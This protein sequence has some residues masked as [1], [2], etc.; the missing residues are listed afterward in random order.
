SGDYPEWLYTYTGNVTDVNGCIS[1]P[2]NV[3]MKFNTVPVPTITGPDPVCAGSTE[4]YITEPGMSGYTWFVTGGTGTSV[5]NSISVVWGAGGT[6]SV[7]VNYTDPDGCTAASATIKTITIYYELTATIEADQTI[8]YN[9]VPELLTSTVSGGQGDYTYQWQILEGGGEVDDVFV[10]IEGATNPTYQPG[11]L[12]VTTEYRLVV[13]DFC[14]VIETNVVTI[15]VYEELIATIAED[16]TICYNTVPAELTSTVSGGNGEYLYHWAQSADGIEWEVITGAHSPTYQPPALIETTYYRLYV[17]DT[18]NCGP[19]ITNTVIITV[20]DEFLASIEADQTIC[21]NTVP[22]LLTSTVSGGQGDYEYQWQVLEGGGE[23]DDVFVDIEGATDPTYQP[24]A[25]LV[26]TEYRLIVTDYCGVIETNSVTITVYDEFLASIEADQ[27]ICYNTVPELLTSSVSGGQGEYEYQ[28]QYRLPGETE[29]AEY[30]YSLVD[31]TGGEYSNSYDEL[32]WTDNIVPSEENVVIEGVTLN[33]GEL[34]VDSWYDEETLLLKSPAGTTVTVWTPTQSGSVFDFVFTTDVFNGENTEGTWVLYF[35]DS[36]GDGG[37]KAYD[38]TLCL[39][40]TISS[41]EITDWADIEGATE[42]TYQPDALM[43]TTEYRLFVIDFCGEIYT[44]P[45]VITV[46][47]PLAVT[48]AA[49]QLS[50]YLTAPELLTSEATGGYGNYQYQWQT[51]DGEG[52]TDIED[53]TESTYQPATLIGTT[54]YRLILTDFCG[55]VISNEVTITIIPLPTADAG[56][57]ALIC[58]NEY[59]VLQGTATY[60]SSVLWSTS[61]DGEF[62]DATLLNATYFPGSDDIGE[63]FVNLSLTAYALEPCTDIATDVMTI[64]FGPLPI[65][66]AGSDATI[67]E[68]E[69][70][71]TMGWTSNAWTTLWTTDG[72]GYFDN[73]ISM[74]AVY[75]PGDGDLE[76]GSVTLILSATSIPP[77]EVIESDEVIVTFEYQPTANAG[78]D[79]TICANE[80]YTLNGTASNYSSITW[81]TAGDGSFS[82][83]HILHP[84]YTPGANDKQNGSVVLTLTAVAIAPC[85]SNAT[86]SMILHITLQPT[87]NAGPNAPVC[88]ASNYMLSGASASNYSSVL[89]TTS[90]TGT[91][92]NPGIVNATYVP[93]NGDIYNGTVTLTL[94]AISISP[95]TGN[96]TDNMVLTIVK[97]PTANAG[98][99]AITCATAPFTLDGQAANY[100]SVKWTTTGDGVFNNSNILNAIYT[101]GANDVVNGTVTLKL[102]AY[103]TV[104]CNENA[105]DQMV[106]T[107]IKLPT[108]NAG[109]DSKICEEETYTLEGA[110]TN[111]DQILWI[112]SGDGGFNNNT[113]LDAIY[114]PGPLDIFNGYCVLTLTAYP[115]EPCMGQATDAM[116]LSID[117]IPDQPGMPSG[118]DIV[119]VETGTA[120]S[121][122]VTTGSPSALSYSWDIYPANAG[123]IE[124]S[125]SEAT[126]FWSGDYF[127]PVFIKVAGI[128]D[129]GTGGFSEIFVVIA[130]DCTGLPDDPS[131]M[132][133]MKVFP[134]PSDGRFTMTISGVGNNIDLY[135]VGYAGQILLQDR[136]QRGNGDYS[137]EFDLSTYPKGVYF[138]KVVGENV[139]KIQKIVIR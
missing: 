24:D 32:G 122:Y 48:I 136:I 80:T 120:A 44:E 4:T 47:D 92:T 95:C 89:W 17:D 99:D 66:N 96:I 9:T 63:G 55:E 103:A 107:V 127:G 59:Y 34:W 31:F 62:D 130:D 133:S 84:V 35:D 14:G 139:L 16:Q 118:D 1:L 49:D 115:F 82:N 83:I 13:T 81:T 69:S 58:E 74:A 78:P 124:G 113:I 105:V 28:W 5:T 134:N 76:A 112:S 94:T 75:Y 72:D 23:V 102:T 73:P 18:Y 135:L 108:A 117:R 126:V 106:L 131:N 90:G 97:K 30:C 119:C 11:A 64:E 20:Y 27:S 85:A 132:V 37:G 12:L 57:D 19:I 7:S 25:L 60:Y 39:S 110:A 91:F 71:Q 125:G 65:V 2:M 88:E 93:S 128:N 138:L 26:T 53:A 114:S 100:A 67:C 36:Y 101:P 38:V 104:P 8:C 109:Q 111:Y 46:Y 51:F 87:A 137:K 129:C 45:I 40:Y 22:E 50:C 70:F 41:G 10:D 29:I 68:N 21:Y 77:C 6:G 33:I 56:E 123:T 86:D 3:N 98:P 15:T 79:A 42:P 116:T 61:G 43:V 121:V 54:L 52:W